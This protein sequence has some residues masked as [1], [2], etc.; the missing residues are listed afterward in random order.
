M[1]LSFRML[2][3]AIIVVAILFIIYT[4]YLNV[5]PPKSFADELKDG[6]ATANTQAFLGEYFLITRRPIPGGTIVNRGFFD[7]ENMSVSFECT[8]AGECCPRGE[9]CEKPVEWDYDKLSF[10]NEVTSSVSVRCIRY[11]G[12]PACKFYFVELPAQAKINSA[13]LIEQDGKEAGVSI[14]VENAGKQTLTLGQLSLALYKDVKGDWVDTEF[15]SAPRELESLEEGK[16]HRFL[17]DFDFEVGGNYMAEFKF[18]GSNAGFDTAQVTID[19]KGF[20]AC[21]IDRREPETIAIIDSDQFREIHYC[22]GCNTAYECLSA[23]NRE[24]PEFD[25]ELLTKDS[26]YCVKDAFEGTCG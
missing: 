24:Y 13:E 19:V 7:T 18:E 25:Y 26:V 6:L 15:V 11:G 2:V 17:W 12:T 16:K 14:E 10:K 20:E 8:S 4:I 3:Y 21:D 23:W 9:L 1:N 22:I 5:F